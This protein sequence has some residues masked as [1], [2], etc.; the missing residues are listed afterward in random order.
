MTIS[1]PRLPLSQAQLGIWFGQAL[2]PA[3]PSY[4]TA[5][6]LDLRGPLDLARLERA[7]RAL[8]DHCESLRMVFGS[9]DAGQ[10][11]QTPQPLADNWRLPL[12]DLSTHVQPQQAAQA[13]I[14]G[15]LQQAADL[16]VGPLY[17][18]GLLKLAPDHHRLWLAAHHIALDGYGY[19]LLFQALAERYR[20]QAAALPDWGMQALIDEE[21][22][23]RQSPA[24]LRD[25]AFWLQAMAAAK[26]PALLAPPRP[27]AYRVARLAGEL[28]EAS[29][30]AC[31]QAARALAVD[32]PVLLVA[33]IAA[34][35]YQQS[36]EAAQ[37][38]GWP[39]MNRLG[40]LAI[41]RPC[42]AM[43]IVPL[44]LLI[45]PNAGLDALVQQLLAQL[46]AIRPHQ[47]YRHEQL[48]RDL[49]RIG[50][51]KRL[52][53]AVVNLMPFERTLAF[54]ELA[55][56]PLALAAGPVEDLAINLLPGPGGMHI[57][58]HAHPD[59][60][61]PERLAVLQPS[62]FAALDALWRDVREPL[63]QALPAVARPPKA[64]LAIVHGEPL[65]EPA[66]DVLHAFA[67]HAAL[68]AQQIALQTPD[69]TVVSYGELL[70]QV[71][72]LAGRLR[73]HGVVPGA[74]V[75]IL[76]PRAPQTVAALLA[77]LWAGAAYLPLDPAAPPARIAELLNDAAPQLM[78]TE[79]AHAALAGSVPLLCF[80]GQCRCSGELL[81]APAALPADAP[82][83]LMYTSGSSGRPKR[84]QIAR[85]A[86][87]HFLAAANQR[88]RFGPADRVLQF[89]PLH[90][91]ASVEEIFLSL[92]QGASLV[93]RSE[94][95]LMSLPRFLAEC[96][97]L[98]ISV[99]D[100]PTAFWHELVHC[101]DQGEPQLPASL[102]LLIIGGEAALAERLAQW[103][104]LAPP[105]LVLLN[106]YG[107]TETTVICSTALLAGPHASAS[108]AAVL[109]IG[110][111]LPGVSLLV[112]DGQLQPVALGEIGE[113]CVLGPVLAS[114]YPGNA[115]ET[116]QRFVALPSLPGSPR[117]YRTGDLARLAADG[118]LYY[119]GR[120]D[121]EFKLS[122]QR[123]APA[124]V[125]SALL[126][127][128][129]ISEAAVL[130]QTLAGGIKRL[131]AFV[132][133]HPQPPQPAS[134]VAALRS[135][136]LQQL[137]AV[138][139]PGV[140][141]WLD[142][143]P[144]NANGKIDRPQLAALL[145]QA[146]PDA[147]AAAQDSILTEMERQVAAVWREVLACGPL[148][149]NDDFFALGGKSLQAIQVANRLQQRLG[150]AVT[151]AALF[152]HPSLAALAHSLERS[153]AAQTGH[154]PPETGSPFAPMLTIQ[155]G[156]GPALFCLHPAEGLA[157]C[158]FG[159]APY[160]PR[161][162]LYGLQAAGLSGALPASFASQVEAAMASLRSVQPQ[163]PYRL[164][165]WSSGGA[166]AQ[167]LAVALQEAGEEVDMLALLDAY[168]AE[169]WVGKPPP[170]ERDALEALLDISGDS[171]RDAAGQPLSIDA[172]LAL[173]RR[174]G[175]PLAG[176]DAARISNLQTVALHTM[177]LFRSHATPR[178]HG[179]LLLFR[180]TRRP[181]G[182]PDWQ[183]WQAW[184]HGDIDCIDVDAS[185]ATMT[186]PLALQTIGP[187]LAARLPAAA[188]SI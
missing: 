115:A 110:R 116:R 84:V 78:I 104:R 96:A 131:V 77:V 162:P 47:R 48:R 107:P 130:G 139:V 126:R 89:A 15:Q 68:H 125:E 113:L 82:A 152:S 85:N 90:F 46:R 53:G 87:N 9:D 44:P 148:A 121:D 33:A 135:Q 73:R 141:R 65:A 94:A 143:L 93:L 137:P 175:S 172:M 160:L 142:S 146:E 41:N 127:C 20:D 75:A 4:W 49:G 155:P 129:G 103:R 76:V 29:W 118:Q 63:A 45:D 124:E 30:H 14:D 92:S 27:L 119:Q 55:A 105:D 133:M 122:G 136:L 25:Q 159:L 2:D 18:C 54:G 112:V 19:A 24:W 168:P 177:Q 13:H 183:H 7:M 176:F 64:D 72:Q 114:G 88:Y 1:L 158:Y 16:T 144:R 35:L 86:L 180:A 26:P 97:R 188:T 10:L 22:A 156:D 123:I 23:Y 79:P 163:G 67:R 58:L 38:L 37:T 32:A 153:R 74:G 106:S 102:R 140:Y 181:G 66:P 165:G 147:P 31:Q 101:L 70:A 151:V 108:M 173:L 40:S 157:W 61:P 59:A 81:L 138:A 50:G 185:H 120:L 170:C 154:R 117:A 164:L 17:R 62:L 57:A 56:Q 128:T 99:L 95:M 109:P 69:G 36:G 166:L 60:Y 111:P 187:A 83:Y 5:E 167:A 186:S 51:D 80:E 12:L 132:V 43:N 21:Q 6:A 52:F 149:P 178:Y 42:M 182:G 184:I 3:N 150:Q 98:R 169:C 171:A 179:D 8:L 100:L 91:D 11:W 174:P 71:Q 145:Q 39:V 34:W 134:E 28:P 161:V